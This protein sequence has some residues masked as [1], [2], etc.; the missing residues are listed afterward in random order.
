MCIRDRATPE[1]LRITIFR[2]VDLCKYIAT[3]YSRRNVMRKTP[4]E[5]SESITELLT[6][7]YE[8]PNRR[9]FINGIIANVIETRAAFPFIRALCIMIQEICVN[10]LH[11]I[12][13]IFD[14]GP[15]PHKILSLI[16]IWTWRE[17]PWRARP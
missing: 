1:W 8:D 3:K 4:K 11:I 13:D 7:N 5:F 9:Q 16:H 12:G 6:A 10:T 2:L 14:R 17:R 15:G